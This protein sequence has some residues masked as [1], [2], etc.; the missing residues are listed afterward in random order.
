MGTILLKY[1]SH[2][3]GRI[4]G[5]ATQYCDYLGKVFVKNR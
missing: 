3:N 1:S 5:F 4:D 2:R